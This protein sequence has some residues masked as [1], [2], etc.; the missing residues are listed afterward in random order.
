[1]KWKTFVFRAALACA[2]LQQALAWG[3]EGHS[4][5]AEIAQHRLSANTMRTIKMLLGGEVSLASISA[6]ADDVVKLRPE[7]MAWHFVNIPFD[8]TDYDPQR[9]CRETPRGDCIINA[10]RRVE[11]TLADQ[12][13]TRKTRTEALMFLVHFIGDVHQPLHVADRHDAGGNQLMVTLFGQPMSLHA[14]WDVGLIEKHTYDWG[15]YSRELESS[16]IAGKDVAAL[17]RGDPVEWAL[18]AHAI[19]VNV[20][21]KLPEDL[22]LDE[23]YFDRSLPVVNQQL[24]LAGIRLARIL[25]G[26]LGR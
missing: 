4:I 18:E 11:G 12:S 22:R 3:V 24:S 1:M 16:W 23:G 2:P 5:I 20:V 14:V 13:A 6:W 9:D 17:Q 15:A 21:Y 25:N 7:T 26:L 10:I 8:A 19:A